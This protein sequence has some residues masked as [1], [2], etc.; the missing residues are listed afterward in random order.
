MCIRPSTDSSSSISRRRR[1]CLCLRRRRRRVKCVCARE[2]LCLCCSV[3]R[4]ACLPSC[5]HPLAAFGVVIV[6]RCS[7]TMP[8]GSVGRFAV[9]PSSPSFTSTAHAVL[10]LLLGVTVSVLLFCRTTTTTTRSSSSSSQQQQQCN[11]SAFVC[12]CAQLIFFRPREVAKEEAA[13]AEH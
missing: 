9:S 7:H 12:A 8:H 4:S 13:A 1:R 5:L 11:T 10:R 2:C 6:S 3:S